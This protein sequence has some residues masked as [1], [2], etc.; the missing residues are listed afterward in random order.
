VPEADALSCVAGYTCLNDGSIRDWQLDR[1]V[2]QGKNFLASGACGPWMVTA[3]EIPDPGKLVVASRLNGQEMQ[4][5][6][7]EHLLFSVPTL[8]SYYS[9]LTELRPGD[10]ISTGTPPGVGHRRNPPVFMRS[11]DVI[12]VEIGGL[13][14]LRNAIVDE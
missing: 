13:G 5:S 4:R 3:D 14:I 8:I 12:E 6:S 10:I 9:T 7:T 11:G 1:D 2:I